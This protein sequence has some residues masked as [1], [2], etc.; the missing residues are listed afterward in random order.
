MISRMILNLTD[1]EDLRQDLWVSYLTT[2]STSAFISIIDNNYETQDKI[3]DYCW[4]LCYYD[5]E[6]FWKELL[7]L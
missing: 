2:N 1:D 3:L 6:D 4:Q 5:P 7:W